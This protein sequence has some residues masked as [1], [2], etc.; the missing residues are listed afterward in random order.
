M[1]TEQKECVA[2]LRFRALWNSPCELLTS[3][4]S[5]PLIPLTTLSLSI[6]SLSPLSSPYTVKEEGEDHAT[7][8]AFRADSEKAE[9][10]RVESVY[11]LAL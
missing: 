10:V 8:A 11:K 9:A 4:V 1:E 2:L 3:H 5:T 7:G 6:V